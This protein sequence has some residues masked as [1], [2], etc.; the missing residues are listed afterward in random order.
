MQT[1]GLLAPRNGHAI[2]IGRES[3]ERGSCLL[4]FDAFVY[5]N[6]I[7]FGCWI[8]FGI[9][10]YPYALLTMVVSL[11]AIFLSTLS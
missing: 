7:C 5:I 10:N 8:G 2:E 9:E 3:A 11:E 1:T 4:G 6:V